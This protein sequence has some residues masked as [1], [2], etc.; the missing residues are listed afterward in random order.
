MVYVF[1][2][3]DAMS[4]YAVIPLR[5]QVGN[6]LRENEPMTDCFDSRYLSHALQYAESKGAKTIILEIDSPAG[7]AFARNSV[8]DVLAQW[9]R[10]VRLVAYVIDARSAAATIAL[11]CPTL[12]PDPS[13]RLGASLVLDNRTGNTVNERHLTTET[14]QVRGY[15]QRAGYAGAIADAL[16]I[17]RRELW[18]H[19][20]KGFSTGDKH[21]PSGWRQ[22]SGQGWVALDGPHSLLTL[23]AT[24][25]IDIGLAPGTA[26]SIDQVCAHLGMDEP[27]IEMEPFLRG[28]ERKREVTARAARKQYERIP[29]ALDELDEYFTKYMSIEGKEDRVPRKK[30]RAHLVEQNRCKVEINRR[31]SEVVKNAKSLL[32]KSENEKCPMAFSPAETY[33]VRAIV[34]AMEKVRQHLDKKE[35]DRAYDDFKEA[36]RQ[37]DECLKESDD[38]P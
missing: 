38:F 5:G 1:L 34:K 9:Q 2:S 12:V 15:I 16:T 18:W 26:A 28:L 10:R 32:G 33:Q 13:C 17:E 27:C 8:C 35:I 7:Y 6:V 30:R 25:L 19:P 23:T 4:Q 14:A 21:Y 29:E 37:W 24:E 22:P 36:R 11:S 20:E 31:I 3:S